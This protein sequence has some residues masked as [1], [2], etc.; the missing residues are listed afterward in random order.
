MTPYEER[1][2]KEYF[3]YNKIQD[4]VMFLSYYFIINANVIL[5][6]NSEKYGRR[7]YYKE[8]EYNDKNDNYARKISREFD[9]YLSMENLKAVN[10]VKEFIILRGRDLEF[11]RIIL[12]PYLNLYLDN[13]SK[14]YE[15]RDGKVYINNSS[16][17]GV[18]KFRLISSNNILSFSPGI[19][20]NTYDDSYTQCIDFIINDNVNNIIK[21]N[22]SNLYEFIYMIRTFQIQ[23]YGS[24]MINYLQRPLL[25]TNSINLTSGIYPDNN[26][27]FK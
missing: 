11:L 9:C 21:I 12:L 24:T 1:K 27:F 15:N 5:Y 26:G 13:I 8:I 17:G 14:I 16:I 2:T 23:L 20:K 19:I 3:L 25:G 6:S 18:C 10:N 22:H 4:R 7:S